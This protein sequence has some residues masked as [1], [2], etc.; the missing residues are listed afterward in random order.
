MS[1]FFIECGKRIRASLAAP[2]R[3]PTRPPNQYCAVG[4]RVGE[5][6][7]AE[8]PRRMAWAHPIKTPGFSSESR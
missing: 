2:A 4:G 1:V 3:S 8:S 7:G 6:A 5:R